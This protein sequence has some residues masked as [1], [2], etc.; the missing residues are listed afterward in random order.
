[1]AMVRTVGGKWVTSVVS[2]AQTAVDT[3][4]NGRVSISISDLRRVIAAIPLIGGGYKAEVTNISGNT[5]TITV[6]QYD[7]PAAAAG[8]A[9]ALANATDVAPLTIIAVGE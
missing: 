8:A 9:V 3:D 1:M 5:V 2:V 6:Y 4:A 7:Y